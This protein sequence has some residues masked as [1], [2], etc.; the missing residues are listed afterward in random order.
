MCL[1]ADAGNTCRALNCPRQPPSYTK[2][3]KNNFLVTFISMSLWLTQ[4]Q[5]KQ[6][7]V[8]LF[9]GILIIVSLSSGYPSF[10]SIIVI[11][12][13]SIQV[14]ASLLPLKSFW[15]DSHN[16]KRE[17]GSQ[18]VREMSLCCCL[19]RFCRVLFLSREIIRFRLIQEDRTKVCIEW[20]Y[21]SSELSS[22]IGLSIP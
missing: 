6:N 15:Q 9:N 14:L 8:I 20:L 5:L 12:L 7:K 18:E 4:S 1:G 17:V 11:F 22:T 16:V 13:I 2:V 3:V 10:T 21:T 19:L